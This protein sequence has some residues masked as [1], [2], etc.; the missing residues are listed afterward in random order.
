MLSLSLTWQLLA[1]IH[2]FLFKLSCFFLYALTI[3][4]IAK[5]VE[6]VNLPPRQRFAC[7]WVVDE[8]NARAG[9]V[10]ATRKRLCCF[11]V[12][13]RNFFFA[14]DFVNMEIFF[15][16]HHLKTKRKQ[17]KSKPD[18]CRGAEWNGR[19][20]FDGGESHLGNKFQYLIY[21]CVSPW[22]APNLSVTLE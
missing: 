15:I 4:I 18:E 12:L 5:M 3:P 7:I 11:V 8:I 22:S 21:E 13:C 2:L 10:G 20:S 16:V 9:F 19:N 17:L 6:F 1:A 14:F